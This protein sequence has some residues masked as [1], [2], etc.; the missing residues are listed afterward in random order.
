MW[1]IVRTRVPPGEVTNVFRGEIQA[2]DS[3]L[4]TSLG[5]FPLRE[6]LAWDYQYRQV[7]GVLFLTFA[8]I[9][10]L[11]ASLGLYAV[12]AYS[13]GQRTQEFGVRIA[14]GATARDILKLVFLQ[15]MIPLGIGLAAGL[16]ASV[17]VNRILK[18]QLVH[19]SPADPIA[20]AVASA[21]LIVAATFGCLIPARRAMRVDPIA[22]LRHE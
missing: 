19:V 12:I 7:S 5:P 18:S 2:M 17:A 14:V 4:P 13:V 21:T 11:L 16:A 10:L 8:A 3:A 6:Y 9:A 1:V 22:A 20:L 15:G